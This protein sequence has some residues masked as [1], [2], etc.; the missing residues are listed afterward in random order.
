MTDPQRRLYTP[1]LDGFLRALTQNPDLARRSPVELARRFQLSPDLVADVL[2]VLDVHRQSD[3]VRSIPQRVVDFLSAGAGGVVWLWREFAR[4]PLGFLAAVLGLGF[5]A[6]SR[7]PAG[8]PRLVQ[9]EIGLWLG[10]AAAISSVFYFNRRFRYPLAATLG[11]AMLLGWHEVRTAPAA[12][13]PTLAETILQGLASCA[14]FFAA[15]GIWSIWEWFRNVIYVEDPVS[16]LGRQQMIARLLQL[17][18]QVE[19][20]RPPPP[21]TTILYTRWAQMVRSLSLLVGFGAGLLARAALQSE[22]S[23]G[24]PGILM[25]L[26]P[27]GAGCVGFF[28]VDSAI[29]LLASVLFAIGFAVPDLFLS[30]GLSA[31]LVNP[32]ALWI[33]AG[34]CG[35]GGSIAA[36]AARG[37]YVRERFAMGDTAS[38]IAEVVRLQWKLEAIPSNVCVMVVDV[39]GSTGMKHGANPL[40]AEYSFRE[41]Q[42]FVEEICVDHGGRVHSTAGD[43]A[44][45][46]F[47]S[48][49]RAAA[50]AR[51]IQ[52]GLFRFNREVNR[53]PS[54]FHLRIG[55]H[56]DSVPGDLMDVQFSRVIDVAAHVETTA[57]IGGIALTDSVAKR[58]PGERLEPATYSVDGFAVF[59]LPLAEGT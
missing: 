25:A 46:G 11:F 33:L 57:P 40:L 35:L 45:I 44:I 55:M 32:R 48:C 58:L 39:A 14:A 21:A 31:G 4:W 54:A 56:M 37:R 38:S 18:K 2:E 28:S 22:V 23:M 24:G 41:Y 30:T 16:G 15:T 50:A 36:Q 43:G 17:Q 26:I 20:S 8:P 9:A 42:R 34:L 19:A 3:L 51:E 53:L 1:D 12:N 13:L 6:M 49:R 59:H 10:M 7:M 5:I 27:L 47:D 29:A 52:R